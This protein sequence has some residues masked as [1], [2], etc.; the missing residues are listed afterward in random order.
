MLLIVAAD[1]MEFAGLQKHCVRITELRLPVDW[2]RG[3]DLHG[4]EIVMIA[5]GAGRRRAAKAVDAARQ[6]TAIVNIGFCGALDPAL[7][8]GDVFV[9]TSI[10][11]VAIGA[12][13]SSFP[14][15]SG[16]LA[17]LDHVA[18]S[19]AEKQKL[20]VRGASVVEMEAAGVHE[21]A[22]ALGLPFFCVRS[23]T[24]L[25]GETFA[26]DFN[27]AL[28]EDGHFGTMQILRS[29][30]LRPVARL[31]ELVRLR[32]RCAIAAQNLGEF[33]ANCRF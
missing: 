17:S 8:I 16:D 15:V 12:P 23:V 19:A 9:A 33:I 3:A 14:Y 22:Q 11:G 31:P 5:N 6:A 29:A 13:Q 21:R 18:Q 24:D 25:A 28:R 32:K 27:A 10:A 2:A 7:R 30:M 20:R 26:N 1:P 4:N